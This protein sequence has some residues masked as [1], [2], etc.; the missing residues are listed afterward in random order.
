MPHRTLAPPLKDFTDRYAV[1]QTNDWAYDDWG[2][3]ASALHQSILD[4][5]APGGDPEADLE[6]QVIPGL[7]SALRQYV[8]DGVALGYSPA[9]S[10]TYD[11]MSRG[12]AYGTKEGRML[13][14]AN[15]ARLTKAADGIMGHVKDIKSMLSEARRAGQ[16]QGWPVYGEAS[17]SN[18]FEEKEDAEDA[19]ALLGTLATRLEVENDLREMHEIAMETSAASS[20]SAQ[21]NAALSNLIASH[22]KRR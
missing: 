20:P 7:L 21:V 11:Y 16:L 8:A 9:D 22:N 1:Q 2:D 3:V 10:S 15:H 6:T 4:L 13:S 18:Y 14:A 19:R 12:G 17:S 5:F